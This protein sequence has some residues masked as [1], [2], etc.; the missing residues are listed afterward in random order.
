M[1]AD[2]EMIES[3]G[4]AALPEWPAGTVVILV[5]AGTEPHAIPV[6]AALRAGPRRVLL[7][8]AARR[9]SL[10]RLR[11][12]PRVALSITAG[13]D[14]AVTAYGTAVAVD[15]PLADG[16]VGVEVSVHRV[17]DHSRPTFSIES[18]VGW[19]WT[20]AEARRRDVAV[21]DAL[22]RLARVTPGA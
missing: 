17:Q 11:E 18:G 12:D 10:R 8:L 13:R 4:D 14:I 3:E 22:T 2:D 20:D 5:T 19:R 7:G 16:V 15:E 1:P 9:E 21:R 6:S